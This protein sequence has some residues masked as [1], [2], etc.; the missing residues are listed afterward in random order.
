MKNFW[1]QSPL[2]QRKEELYAALKAALEVEKEAGRLVLSAVLYDT[3]GG[4]IWRE[5]AD[6]Y[7]AAA[8]AAFEAMRAS[9]A[10]NRAFEASPA[11]QARDRY[12]RDP[13]AFREAATVAEEVAA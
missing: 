1:E 11:G 12:L 4:E 10:A 13:L 5:R 3:M 2:W 9:N 8:D 6:A 7:K